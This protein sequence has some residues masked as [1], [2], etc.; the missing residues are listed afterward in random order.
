MQKWEYTHASYEDGLFDPRIDQDLADITVKDMGPFLEEAG[1]K[2][3]E[4]CA[5]LPAS[6]PGGALGFIFKRPTTD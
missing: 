6:N 2:G 1:R 5:V 3:W 4:L